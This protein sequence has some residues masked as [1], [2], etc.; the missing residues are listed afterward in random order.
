MQYTYSALLQL[1]C[2]INHFSMSLCEPVVRRTC[3]T[4]YG[5]LH[6]I[7]ACIAQFL[8]LCP[9]NIV[10]DGLYRAPEQTTLTF[11]LLDHLLRDS[12]VETCAT[13]R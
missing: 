5:F 13:N 10:R 6:P 3:N 12:H 9:L 2:S 1:S 8:C 7:K 11:N 4:C